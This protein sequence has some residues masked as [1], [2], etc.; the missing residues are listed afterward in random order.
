ME[1][2]ISKKRK[3]NFWRSFYNFLCYGGF[4]LIIF[5]GFGI[6]VLISVLTK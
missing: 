5:L 3:K 2:A 1:E 4:M 6:F